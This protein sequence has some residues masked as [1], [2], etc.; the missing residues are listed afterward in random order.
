M[1]DATEKKLFKLEHQLDKLSANFD[2]L[3]G[4]IDSVTR[5][6]NKE[7]TELYDS[8]ANFAKRIGTLEKINKVLSTIDSE[9]TSL[10][11]EIDE[12]R[13]SF[14]KEVEPLFDADVENK[15]KFK[16]LDAIDKSILARITAARTEIANVAVKQA[17]MEKAWNIN[18]LKRT[19]KTVEDVNKTIAAIEKRDSKNVRNLDRVQ[20]GLFSISKHASDIEAEHIDAKMAARELTKKAE[21]L[22]DTMNYFFKQSENL[23][24]R[25][26]SNT[27]S[28]S[29]I[30]STLDLIKDKI[31]ALES[32]S[33]QLSEIKDM[34]EQNA[35]SIDQLTQ[36]IAY[37]E[38]ATVKTIVLE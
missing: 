28:V 9:L 31:L 1:A 13:K 21:N 29:E 23:N 37:L 26:N 14:T 36:R 4:E 17:A 15:K 8:D 35:R 27:T 18:V 38:K 25:I 32:Q 19:A 11:E 10:H 30:A 7:V 12:E 20:S 3:R 16:S 33:A 24:N 5:G 2:S 34:L 22:K 6:F